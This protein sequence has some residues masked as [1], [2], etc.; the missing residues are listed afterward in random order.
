M[1][2]TM[3][4]VMTPNATTT[5]TTTTQTAATQTATSTTIAADNARTE[6]VFVLD[7]SGSMGGRETD[8]IGNFNKVIADQKS[9]P[10]EC[11]V[12]V[13]LFDDTAEVLLDRVPLA[14]V[15]DL[16]EQDYDVRGCTAYYDALG[17]AIR[18]HIR[19]QR[20]LPKE[21]RAEKVMFVV[22][23]DGM[24][25]ASREYSGAALRRL[26]AEEQ[27]KWGWE[28]LFFGADIDAIEAAHHIGIKAE[29]AISIL[30]DSQGYGVSYACVSSAIANVRERRAMSQNADGTSYRAEVDHDY[31]VRSKRK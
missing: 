19:V 22:M 3:N 20:H 30:G 12:S 25:N 24:E 15:R 2:K 9:R 14:D 6:V 5:Q 8:V 10:G 1:T 17:R 13:V 11:T 28:F 4:N 16:T 31:A 26:L 23:T 21:R 29:N 18:H 27:K 7:R